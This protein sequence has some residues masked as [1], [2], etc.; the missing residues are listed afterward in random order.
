MRRVGARLGGI[1][2]EKTPRQPPPRR[3]AP[4]H[5]FPAVI[6]LLTAPPPFRHFA[7]CSVVVMTKRGWERGWRRR[8]LSP[9]FRIVSPRNPHS[10]SRFRLSIGVF[11]LSQSRSRR[12]RRGRLTSLEQSDRSV[13]KLLPN[14]LSLSLFLS[15]SLSL[16]VFTTLIARLAHFSRPRRAIDF[17]N[18]LSTV[19]EG[20]CLV[21]DVT[22]SY[23]NSLSARRLPSF[24][25]GRPAGSGKW[26][27][28]GPTRRE[29]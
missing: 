27:K 5:R 24:F 14:S 29:S 3:T 4:R 25:E 2:R 8:R 10:C 22:R 11:A 17:C 15:F 18:L 26:R 21:G 9:P 20:G 12:R 13:P 23:I 1:L 6:K 7:P 19:E 16:L 28:S